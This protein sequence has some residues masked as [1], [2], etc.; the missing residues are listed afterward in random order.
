MPSAVAAVERELAPERLG[1]PDRPRQLPCILLARLATDRTMQRRGIGAGLLTD[2][3]TRAVVL[4]DSVGAAAVLVHAR[5]EDA[6]AFYQ[7]NGD[8]LESPV[9]SLHLM[10]PMKDLRKFF[11]R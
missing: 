1:G 2:A 11:R 9:E 6:K 3:L 8:F 4:S 7:K 5:D 10:A